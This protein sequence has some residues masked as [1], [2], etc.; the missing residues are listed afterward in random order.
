MTG[1]W[2]WY[3]P[4]HPSR[5]EK[6]HFFIPGALVSVCRNAERTAAGPERQDRLCQQ[7]AA[8]VERRRSSP[9][10]GCPCCGRWSAKLGIR[11]SDCAIA[12]RKIRGEWVPMGMCPRKRPA[13][14]TKPP[15]AGSDGPTARKASR[16][17][18][19]PRKGV[20]GAF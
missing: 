18:S 15:A 1:L 2:L 19:V 7:C 10:T 8:I 3:T 5:P 17:P 14:P 16:V 4:A 9:A 11:C 12:C 6:A 20:P 13:G